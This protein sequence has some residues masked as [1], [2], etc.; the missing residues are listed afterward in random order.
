MFV[1]V[2]CET[3]SLA[4]R[5]QTQVHIFYD[6]SKKHKNMSFSIK[7]L[8]LQLL[9]LWWLHLAFHRLLPWPNYYPV[10]MMRMNDLLK[11]CS[12]WTLALTLAQYPTCSVVHQH[13]PKMM[14][15]ALFQSWD[16]SHLPKNKI[17]II[18]LVSSKKH[19]YRYKHYRKS[20]KQTC[21]RR[22][23][24]LSFSARSSFK[25]FNFACFLSFSTFQ[26]RDPDNIL[27]SKLKSTLSQED[28]LNEPL[29]HHPQIVPKY[30]NQSFYPK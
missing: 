12:A 19:V 28:H 2:T 23:R 7:L 20:W 11:M 3:V 14:D 29:L 17:T 25:A 8:T 9:P 13:L 1:W 18:F 30:K 10:L 15:Q 5:L 22:A 26:S 27:Y 6:G 16:C 21:S 24:C 4:L